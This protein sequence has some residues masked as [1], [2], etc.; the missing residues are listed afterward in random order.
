MITPTETALWEIAITP[1]LAEE[2]LAGAT[3]FVK[4]DG[5]LVISQWT[6]QTACPCSY[7]ARPYLEGYGY[8]DGDAISQVTIPSQ[9]SNGEFVTLPINGV[10]EVTPNSDG[11]VDDAVVELRVWRWH[12]TSGAVGSTASA[13]ANLTLA[14]YP[15]GG[16]GTNVLS[17]KRVKVAT[18]PTGADQLRPPGPSR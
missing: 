4:V 2:A 5:N 6:N 8:M 17:L 12:T 18:Q 7:A 14:Y 9:G 10:G 15:L 1:G 11:S 13:K 16:T 3:G